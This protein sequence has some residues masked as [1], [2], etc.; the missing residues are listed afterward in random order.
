LFFFSFRYKRVIPSLPDLL[1]ASRHLVCQS[2]AWVVNSDG[3]VKSRI[4]FV[5]NDLLL[6]TRHEGDRFF[7]R[8]RIALPNVEVREKERNNKD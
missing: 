1:V 2:R 6:V 8:F 4:L 5:F 7:L 3:I